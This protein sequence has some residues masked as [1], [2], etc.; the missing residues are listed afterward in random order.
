MNNY[1][2]VSSYVFNYCAIKNIEYD[3]NN[4]EEIKKLCK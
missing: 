2:K 3:L 4:A 1:F